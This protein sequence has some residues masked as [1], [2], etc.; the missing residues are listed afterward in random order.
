MNHPPRSSLLWTCVLL[1]AIVAL[2]ALLRSVCLSAE[3]WLDEIWSWE[4]ARA[5]ATPWEIFLGPNHHH[6]NNHKLNTLYL[7]FIPDSWSFAFYRLHSLVAGVAAVLLA[8][9]AASRRGNLEGLFAALLVAVNYWFVLCAAEARGYALALAFAL[10]AFDGLQRYLRDGSRWYLAQFQIA[11]ILG[12]L[13]HLTFLYVYLALAVWSVYHFARNRADQRPRIDP[14]V[15]RSHAARR[16][17][18]RV[19]SF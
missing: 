18:R 5:A 14:A 4:F 7:F 10:A 11:V 1:A 8:Y 3:L 17:C 16:V 15:A 13:A 2:A 12:F 6:D 19:I 9:R